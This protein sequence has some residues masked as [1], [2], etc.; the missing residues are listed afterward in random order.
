MEWMGRE[1]I[2]QV[3]V[4]LTGVGLTAATFAIT[5]RVL[6]RKPDF[7]LQAGIAG[8]LNLALPL[9]KIVIVENETIGDQG[10]R[11]NG[12]FRS[13]FDLRLT[14]P[15]EYPWIDGKL[16]N[17]LGNLKESE[18]TIV[19]GITVNEISTNSEII[20]YFRNEIG[21]SIETMEGGAL[22]YVALMEQISF[23][24]IRSLSNFV[25]ERD[26]KKWVT[27]LAITSL[28][29]ELKRIL[30]KLISR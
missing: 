16:T 7:I 9:T 26:K 18:L 17:Q 6:T 1:K 22:H 29:I 30:L 4:L 23:L 5:K 25:G 10:V 2:H 15:N 20:D 19:D 27:D 11:E 12:K 24:Q 8:C 21:A 28:N 3:E 13:L 14:E